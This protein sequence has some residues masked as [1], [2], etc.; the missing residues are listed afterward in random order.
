MH[1]QSGRKGRH[2]RRRRRHGREP[3]KAHSVIQRKAAARKPE[4]AHHTA[5][6]CQ[7]KSRDITCNEGMKMLGRDVIGGT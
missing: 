5:R 3:E 7:E 6:T 1:N 4:K 2:A